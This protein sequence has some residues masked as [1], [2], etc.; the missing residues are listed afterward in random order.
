M[1]QEKHKLL[2]KARTGHK[3]S[4]WLLVFDVMNNIIS[5]SSFKDSAGK[6]YE[7]IKMMAIYDLDPY[8]LSPW[9]LRR[10]LSICNPSASSFYLWRDHHMD[11]NSILH[12]K[13]LDKISSFHSASNDLSYNSCS[14]LLTKNNLS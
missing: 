3:P 7:L 5:Q 14:K 11:R 10:I 9:Y 6:F 1:I 12:D 4:S 13:M 2:E 8:N